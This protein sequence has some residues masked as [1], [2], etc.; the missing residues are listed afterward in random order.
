MRSLELFA[1]AGGLALGVS[2]AGFIH[3]GVVEWDHDACSSMFT[4]KSA[5]VEYIRDWPICEA[6]VREIRF[7]RFGEDLDLLAGG[8][9]CQPWSLGGKHRGQED[10]RN[11]FPEMIRA[12]RETNPKSVLIEN[13]KGLL[14]PAFGSYFEYI[15]L[16]LMYP[17]L[18]PRAAETWQQHVRRLEQH[19]TSKRGAI[20][21]YKVVFRLVNSADYGVPQRRERVFLV[22]FRS[23]V[24]AE[25]GFPNPTHSQE[26]LLAAKW[27]TGEYWEKHGIPRK[28]RAKP[29]PRDSALL[30]R[31]DLF[32]ANLEPWRTVRDAFIDLPEPGSR[33]T[34]K[35]TNHVLIDG[36]RSY[37]GHT[38]S[39]LDEPSKALKAGDHGVPGGE[40]TVVRSDG[41]I[42]Y[43]SVREAARVQCFPD[44]YVFP[45]SWT[46][47]MRQ[48]GN[49][50][51]VALAETVAKSIRQH[52]SKVHAQKGNR[53]VA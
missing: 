46:E 38:G 44:H 3:T 12:V 2:K 18:A 14:R 9:P 22:A 39:P 15:L 40:N 48:L 24:N 35:W 29:T 32:A 19:H 33:P 13:V 7:S 6:D 1:G 20:P 36:A 21:E 30:G 16:G 26:S 53:S 43:Y 42:R 52:L 8:V 11:L 47:S 28:A 25:W 10:R 4:N 23:D 50:V 37:P 34:G 45:G 5:G 51:P 41:S 17:S 49:A 31:A 27:I